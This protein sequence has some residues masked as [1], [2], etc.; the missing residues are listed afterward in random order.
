MPFPI[1]TKAPGDALDYPVDFSDVFAADDPLA[2]TQWVFPTILATVGTPVYAG[3]VATAVFDGGTL[4][5]Y[6]SIK[7]IGVSQ[8]GLVKEQT[9]VLKIVEE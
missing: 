8:S 5:E 9:V 6:H 7:V 4:G 1:R 2:S 3:H